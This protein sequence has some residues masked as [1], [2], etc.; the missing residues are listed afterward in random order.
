VIPPKAI[1]AT[2]ADLDWT[3]QRWDDLVEYRLKGTPRPWRQPDELTPEKR[4]ERDALA[5]LEKVELERWGRAPGFSPA[6]LHV[7]TLDVM[8]DVL[9]EADALHETVAQYLGHDRLEPA[10]S[11]FDDP[12]RFLAYVASRVGDTARESDDLFALV[13]EKA[14]A[15]RTAIA[16]ELGEVEDGQT[17]N[18]ICPFCCG[19]TTRH[20]AGGAKTMRF[21]LIEDRLHAGEKEA[22][23]VCES[24]ACEP[25]AAECSLRVRNHPAWRFTDWE[26]LAER[27][28][29]AS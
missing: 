20:P 7:S 27:L 14:A 19:V 26:W 15:M 6:P 29:P 25:F 18:A 16:A 11:A 21:R 5:R 10:I 23:I 28:L 1:R 4:A 13:A 24:G 3:A 8:V 9:A 2:I 12:T 17:L 22:V